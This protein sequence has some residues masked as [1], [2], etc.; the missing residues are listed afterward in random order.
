MKALNMFR[1]WCRFWFPKK[2]SLI[3]I[4]SFLTR[5]RKICSVCGDADFIRFSINNSSLIF[6]ISTQFDDVFLS[7]KED[8]DPKSW[9]KLCSHWN[10]ELIEIN[11]RNRQ[12]NNNK[13]TNFGGFIT[14]QLI[15]QHWVEQT[16]QK[17]QNRFNTVS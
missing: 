2:N 5:V 3:F 13:N 15:T 12:K 11:R 1:Q 16:S 4:G 7:Q 17:F 9:L 6:A 8:K 14:N 10:L